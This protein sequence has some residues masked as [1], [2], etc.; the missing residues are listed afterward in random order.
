MISRIDWPLA[1]M[2]SCA[3]ALSGLVLTSIVGR[4]PGPVM[5]CSFIATF[6]LCVLVSLVTND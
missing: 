6:G 1:L 4:P 5:V 2:C 3:S